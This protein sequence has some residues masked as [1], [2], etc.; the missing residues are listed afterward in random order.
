M[1]HVTFGS[2]RLD[3][4]MH[5][6]QR[7]ADIIPL[8]PKTFA[9]LEYLLARPGRLVTKDEI[10]TAVWP[11]TA[12]SDTV[13]KVCVREVREALGDDPDAPRYIETAHRLGYRFIGL[14]SS[15]NLP[16]PISSLV[17]RQAEIDE[18]SRRFD[19]SRLVTL[20]G[21][22]GSGKSRL[23]I[24]VARSTRDDFAD[25]V[26]WVDLAPVGDERFVVQAAALAFGIRDQPGESLALLLARFLSTREMLLVVDNCEHV[27]GAA[28]DLL[29]S[30]LHRAPRLRILATSRE[31][32]KTAGECICPVS[33]LS[34]PAVNV[35]QHAARQYDAVK[36]FE[37]RARAA[38][39]SFTLSDAN[40]DAVASICRRLDGMPLAIELAAAR[41]SALPV[42]QIATRLDTCFRL[43]TT[44]RRAELPRHETLRA[45]ID[46][47]YDLLT[48]AERRLLR[49]LSVFV[50]SFTLEAVEYVSAAPDDRD[51]DIVET[52]SRLIDKSLVFVSDSGPNGAWRYRLLETVRQYAEE[53]LSAEDDASAVSTR[54]RDYYAR[55]VDDAESTINTSD[56]Q[57]V[58][59]ALDRE[60]ANVRVAIERAL[61]GEA[62]ADVAR[63]T[64]ALFWFWFHR[65]LWREGRTLLQAVLDR[66]RDATPSHARLL[67]GDGVLA[68]A[69]GDQDDAGRRLEECITIARA[70]DDRS[71]MVQALHFLAM[72]RLAAGRSLEG[73]EP[74]EEAVRIARGSNDPFGLA[75]ALA[76]YGVL[77]LQLGELGEARAILEESVERGRAMRDAWAVALPLRNL[78]IMASRLGQFERARQRLEE[79]LEGLA[80]LGEKWFLSRSIETLAEVLAWQGQFERAAHLF[81]AAESLRDAVG[82]PVL[83]FY[84]TDYDEALAR[85]RQALGTAAF[86]HGWSQGRRML[87]DAAVAYALA[88]NN[89]QEQSRAG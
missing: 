15:T 71:T 58:L 19:T 48:T 76:S 62:Y 55:L 51:S 10:L 54:H 83:A 45:A 12:V 47:S 2:F 61:H 35:T 3:R 37:E 36:L 42:E 1:S 66:V 78:A 68:W 7:G 70:I 33:P 79:S 65:G 41:V 84:R 22:G 53:K 63:M 85:T 87:P 59:G 77:L 49:H 8:R 82:A 16:S 27:I 18:I 43:L 34:V 5:R 60:H 4:S 31:P 30:L 75:L 14:V 88:R 44:P 69:Q 6:L 25:G 67:L 64:G 38:S 32:F 9:V 73:R 52:M 86:Q 80:A 74:A 39:A 57:A 20:V 24:E 46:W 29:Q 50:D 72:V 21:A 13:L 17:G 11:D 26:W 23:A 56:R 81:G 89:H 28:G 40:C